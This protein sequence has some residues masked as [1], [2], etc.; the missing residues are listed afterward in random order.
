MSDAT[1]TWASGPVIRA[2]AHGAFRLYEAL[3]VGERGLLGEVVQ[4]KGDELTAQ[5]YE[6][7]TGLEPGT[8]LRGTEA[9][10]CAPLGPSLL[11][12]IYDG[13]LRPLSGLDAPFLTAGERAPIARR[14]AF[15]PRVQP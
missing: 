11:G 12:Q 10:L 2:R 1:L 15:E 14:H 3:A 9:P 5:I 13:L 8:R 7:T 4:L 6:D